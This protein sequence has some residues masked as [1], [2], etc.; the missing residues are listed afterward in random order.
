MK[1]F[2]TLVEDIDLKMDIVDV[3]FFKACLIIFGIMVGSVF[4]ETSRRLRPLL[5]MIW[6]ILFSAL[7]VKLFVLQDEDCD[8]DCK[9]KSACKK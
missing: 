9:L 4:P 8:W 1:K 2:I 6:M 5:L 7:M 3:G